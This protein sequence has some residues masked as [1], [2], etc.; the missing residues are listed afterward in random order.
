MM[1]SSRPYLIRALYEWILDNGGVPHLL[2]AAGE[3]KNNILPQEY[4]EEGKIILDLSP[5]AVRDLLISNELIE[6]CGR[7][8]DSIRHISFPVD[9]VLAIYNEQGIGM[10]FEETE[11]MQ[12]TDGD[13][14]P[15]GSS[16]SDKNKK[17]GDSH[18][19]LRVVK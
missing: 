14:S 11:F 13:G 12:G 18:P 8:G 2:V 6:F 15:S 5:E 4:I 10:F 19:H 9:Y 16:G 1:T 17:K 7:F 3:D